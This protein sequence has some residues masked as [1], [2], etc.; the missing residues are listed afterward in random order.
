MEIYA[1][2]VNITIRKFDGKRIDIIIE[3]KKRE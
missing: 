2:I 1:N 3:I